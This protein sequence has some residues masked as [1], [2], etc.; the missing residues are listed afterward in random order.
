MLFV[1]IGRDNK[2]LMTP[3]RILIA[4]DDA[5]IAMYLAQILVGMGHEICATTP[6]RAET[7]SAAAL[8]APD[9]M[10]VDDGLR[11]GS[12]VLAVAEILKSGFVPHIFATGDCYRVLKADP[13]AIVLQKPFSA[14]ALIRAIER[15]SVV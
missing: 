6:D 13:Q 15:A 3:L 5:L 8:H 7:I 1:P 11:D 10:I 2:G 12:G 14:E 9:L 4:E